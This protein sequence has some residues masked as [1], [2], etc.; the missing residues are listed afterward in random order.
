MANVGRNVPCPCGSGKKYKKCHG[1]LR[2][3]ASAGRFYP[4]AKEATI[5]AK[6]ASKISAQLPPKGLPGIQQA[7]IVVPMFADPNDP[8][9]QGGPQGRPGL[10]EVIFTLCRPGFPLTQEREIASADDLSG[11]SHLAIAKPAFT[12][13]D[14]GA[15][16]IKIRTIIEGEAFEFT[17]FPNAKGFLGKIVTNCQA[18]N[19]LDAY[20]KSYGA[21]APSLSNWSI[22]L[23]VPL[24][25]YQVDIKEVRTGTLRMT[26]MPPF[27]ETPFAVVPQAQMPADFR[28]YASLYRE[29]LSSNSPVYQFLCHF[30]IIESIRARR[31]RLGEEARTSGRL[32][33]RP[34]E[35]FPK[36]TE[37]LRAW[38]D[39]IF[40]IRPPTWDDMTVDSLLLPEIVGKRFGAI[41]ESFLQPLRV[42]IAHALFELGELKA[43]F[44]DGFT[45]ERVNRWLPVI[46]CI[47]R[48]MLRTEF[49][50]EFLSYVPDGS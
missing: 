45:S 50:R 42:E 31:S 18:Q 32:F 34:Q 24:S 47:A 46:K 48:R 37:G 26:F 10:Y 16:R 17:G 36:D 38:L 29:A 14:P 15:D 41:F 49:P 27:L 1:S 4:V 30:K 5:P 2:N 25:I 13:P 3:S 12:P 19:F 43:S 11:N 33:T 20:R 44:D 21:L 23:D 9:N 22:H 39:T 6:P 8:R 35:V 28:G 40:A 7:L